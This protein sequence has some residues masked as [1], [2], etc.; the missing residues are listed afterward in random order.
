ML[1]K[2][3]EVHDTQHTKV[4]NGMIRHSVDARFK[5]SGSAAVELPVDESGGVLS[6]GR[7]ASPDPLTSPCQ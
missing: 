7:Q 1:L 6:S 2:I 4:R 5:C 3:E